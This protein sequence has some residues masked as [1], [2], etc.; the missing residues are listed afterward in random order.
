MKWVQGGMVVQECPKA[1]VLLWGLI[2]CKGGSKCSN[3]SP[4]EIEE[5]KVA[6]EGQRDSKGIFLAPCVSKEVFRDPRF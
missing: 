2:G 4:I 6:L 5:S 3:W 1:R